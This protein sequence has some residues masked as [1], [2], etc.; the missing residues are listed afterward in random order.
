M[1][2]QGNHFACKNLLALWLIEPDGSGKYAFAISFNKAV[3]EEMLIREVDEESRSLYTI[4]PISVCIQQKTKFLDKNQKLLF[5]A[6]YTSDFNKNFFELPH[7]VY[8]TYVN[9][10][11]TLVSRAP[12]EEGDQ[13][14]SSQPIELSRFYEEGIMN[15]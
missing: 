10:K 14:F 5:T 13:T 9:N 1:E 3:L 12:P 7:P 4:A 8:A 6:S 11:E 2:E 15:A